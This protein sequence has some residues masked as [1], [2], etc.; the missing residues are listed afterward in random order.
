MR[1]YREALEGFKKQIFEGKNRLSLRKGKEN[2]EVVEKLQ[3]LEEKIEEKQR[4]ITKICEDILNVV[5]HENKGSHAHN[6]RRGVVLTDSES[7]SDEIDDAKMRT[8]MARA[9]DNNMIYKR[10]TGEIG[11]KIQDLTK[12]WQENQVLGTNI[13]ERVRM[14]FKKIMA[15]QDTLE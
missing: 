12:Q 3:K 7:D 10:A 15:N 6:S 8:I 9:T 11:K 5:E 4:E 2:Q 1:D 13:S 14:Q